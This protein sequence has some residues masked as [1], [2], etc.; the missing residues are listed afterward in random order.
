AAERGDVKAQ[1]I[2]NKIQ[3]LTAAAVE[4]IFNAKKAQERSSDSM[5][6]VDMQTYEEVIRNIPNLTEKQVKATAELLQTITEN[7]AQRAGVT[8][9]EYLKN[10]RSIYTEKHLTNARAV[11]LMN[12]EFSNHSNEQYNVLNQPNQNLK[13]LAKHPQIVKLGLDIN[14]NEEA[15][16]ARYVTKT[17]EGKRL[18][19]SLGRNPTAEQLRTA[20]EEQFKIYGDKI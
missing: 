19:G 6:S 3:E 13:G 8:V 10:R 4:T 2:L 16:I 9:E 5:T 1:A 12:V 15:W 18:L 17:E 20:L 7:A 14:N 11:Q